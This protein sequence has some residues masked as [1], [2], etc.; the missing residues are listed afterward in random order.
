M[1]MRHI[2]LEILRRCLPDVPGI[3]G[4]DEYF[5]SVVLLLL[6]SVDGEYHILFQKRSSKIS[7]GGEICLPGGK[8]EESEDESLEIAVLR[9]ASEELGIPVGQMEILGRLDT[10]VAPMGATVDVFVGSTEVGMDE[11]RINTDEVE[12]VFSIPISYFYDVQPEEYRVM[13]EIH[14]SLINR[15]TK[16][17][18]ML[19]PAKELGL[20]EKYEHPWGGFKYKV[21]SY[22]TDEGVIWGITS[23]V[24]K[25]FV[26]KINSWE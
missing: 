6:I 16:Q 17:K 10:I 19:L 23:R 5:N 12:K 9:E 15:K 22:K 7:Q 4:K 20:P 13:I 3:H 25:D 1:R 8:Y 26:E 14:P 11:M 2:N 24:I 18:E 21:F